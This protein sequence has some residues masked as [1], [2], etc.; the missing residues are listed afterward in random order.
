MSRLQRTLLVGLKIFLFGLVFHFI[1]YNFVTYVL[2]I[3]WGVMDLI[4]LWKEIFTIG[5]FVALIYYV[6][7]YKDYKIFMK[8]KTLWRLLLSFIALLVCTLIITLIKWL[9]IGMFVLAFKYDFIGYFIFFTCYFLSKYLPEKTADKLIKRYINLIKILLVFAI[10]WWCALLIK[11][12]VLKIFGYTT[13]SI[14][15]KVGAQPPAVYRTGESQW[16]PRNQFLFE[17]PISWGFFLTAFFPLF[18]MFVL[19]RKSLRNTWF[20]WWV[21]TL[22]VILTFSRAAWGAWIIEIFIL[23]ILNYR[24]HVKKYLLKVAVPLLII[25]AVIAYLGK[26]QIIDRS[27]SN[28]GHLDLF[29]KWWK[30]FTES[31]LIGKGAAYVWPGSHWEG[32]IAFNPEN[33][34]LQIMIEFGIIGFI[35]WMA[36]Y[37]YLNRIGFRDFFTMRK[38][39]DKTLPQHYWTILAM[40]IGMVGL[41]ISGFVLHSFTDRMIVYPMM[42]LFGLILA[43]HTILTW[44]KK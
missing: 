23:W 35:L 42:A 12:G 19:Q 2:H 43:Q 5:F 38:S 44:S 10:L 13:S 8:D 20:W 37:I 16:Y 30:M 28:T 9:G 41:S 40:S 7:R 33:Q 36:T 3:T 27:F 21:F 17:R 11:P 15:W 1:V 4:W 14:E 24:K 32:G 18:Y 22:N 39:K 25:F 29:I 31:P 34:Y 6:V 26:S